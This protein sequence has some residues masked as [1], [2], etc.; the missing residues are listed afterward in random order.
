MKA[1]AGRQTV[2]P[3]PAPRLTS[4]R[5]RELKRGHSVALPWLKYV[6]MDFLTCGCLDCNAAERTTAYF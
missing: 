4:E 1:F 5:S 3:T 2:D 6:Q